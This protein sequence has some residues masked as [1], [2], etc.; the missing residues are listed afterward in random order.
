MLRKGKKKDKKIEN[1][2]EEKK[3]EQLLQT[4]KDNGNE[5]VIAFCPCKTQMVPVR[6]DSIYESFVPVF[7]NDCWSH[8]AAENTVYHCTKGK[9]GRC[10]DHPV[11]YDICES[12]AKKKMHKQQSVNAQE[13]KKYEDKNIMKKLFNRNKKDIK[14]EKENENKQETIGILNINISP[15]LQS[16]LTQQLFIQQIPKQNDNNNNNNNK[17]INK[18]IINHLSVIDEITRLSAL[19]NSTLNQ[20]SYCNKNNKILKH[21]L[22]DLQEVIIKCRTKAVVF[23]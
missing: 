17:E 20:L 12:C 18:N 19:S 3:E 9:K 14:K 16:I 11:G 4:P 10:W 21:S 5:G 2:K 15:T 6:A 7:C 22:C 13:N 8:I 23:S 1:H